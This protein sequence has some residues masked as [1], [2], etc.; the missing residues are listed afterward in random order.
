MPKVDE[1]TKPIQGEERFKVLEDLWL[2]WLQV[3]R[4]K[5]NDYGD[6]FYETWEGLGEENGI[7]SAYT[8]ISDKFNR[9]KTWVLKL[10]HQ[11]GYNIADEKVKDTLMDMAIYALMT[12]TQLTWL[13][14]LNAPSTPPQ[15]IKNV[16]LKETVEKE[17]DAYLIRGPIGNNQNDSIPPISKPAVPRRVEN[18]DQ[19][20][21]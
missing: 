16:I 7:I 21:V 12:V 4:D 1:Y 18:S 17:G 19:S 15:T 6:S 5:N 3:Y 9:F 2:N 14:G 13:E 11:S 20:L 10:R 8:R